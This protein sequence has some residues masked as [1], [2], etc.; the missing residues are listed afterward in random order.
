MYKSYK[1]TGNI[2]IFTKFCVNI[3]IIKKKRGHFLKKFFY[4]YL[5][6]IFHSCFVREGLR[7]TYII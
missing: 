4:S 7:A 6:T 3:L 5:I 2:T 1:R